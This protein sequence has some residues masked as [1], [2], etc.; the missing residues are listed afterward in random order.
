MVD[1][2][3]LSLKAEFQEFFKVRVSHGLDSD[4]AML[5]S[6]IHSFGIFW[7]VK[8][9]QYQISAGTT[10]CNIPGTIMGRVAVGLRI[11]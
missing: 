9:R 3:K 11:T 5:E 4:Q 2:H 7:G 6:Q 1:P 10:T 8:M